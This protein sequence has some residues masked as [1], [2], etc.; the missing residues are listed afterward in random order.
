MIDTAIHT[1]PAICAAHP[2]DAA[3]ILALQKLA[4][5]SEAT[6]YN[7]WTLPPLVQ[8]LPE[9]QA[10]FAT[11]TVLKTQLGD[12]IVGA[13]RAVARDE[14]GQT[15]CAIGRLIVHPDYQ[16]R[17]IGSALLH[18]IEACFPGAARHVLFT[19]SKSTANIRLYQHHGYRISHT[20]RLSAA[21]ELV[22]LE[23]QR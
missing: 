18:S 8:T 7:D 1:Q 5:Q 15:V 11:A 10:E 16:R 6:L 4:Y 19:G 3:E 23:K 17:G 22:F 20:Q 9:L 14:D 2:E 21:V 13:V 12:Q